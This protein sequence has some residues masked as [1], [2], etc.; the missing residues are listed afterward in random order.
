MVHG[1]DAEPHVFAAVQMLAG[2]EVEQT[3][4]LIS[5]SRPCQRLDQSGEAQRRT[6]NKAQR[7]SGGSSQSGT[8]RQR[9]EL[10]ANKI[11]E[12]GG[13]K[14]PHPPERSQTLL[15]RLSSLVPVDD[16]DKLPGIFVELEFDLPL[17][18]NDQLSRGIQKANAL[19]FVRV[20]DLDFA[21]GQ[22][23]CSRLGIVIRLTES[24]LAVGDEADFATS[25]VGI[26]RMKLRS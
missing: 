6:G 9:D 7:D 18:V 25:G 11:H 23:V 4:P 8:S 13:Q 20:V 15:F 12:Q 5:S 21:S 22:V 24:E 2:L 17:F 10:T 3:S 26:R 16:I 19:V 1:V 14:D